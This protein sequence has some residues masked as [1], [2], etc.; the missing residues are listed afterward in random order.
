MWPA[1][2]ELSLS[3]VQQLFRLVAMAFRQARKLDL[4][5]FNPMVEFSYFTTARI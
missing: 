3:Y 2:E 1:Q 5:P 4:I